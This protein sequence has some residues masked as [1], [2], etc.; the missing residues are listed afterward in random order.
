LN[1]TTLI[2]GNG[3]CAHTIAEDLLTTGADIVMATPDTTC[4]F[5]PSTDSGSAE[6]LTGTRLV[7]CRGT[8]GNFRILAA[9][10]HHKIS[11][12]VADIVIAEEHQRKPN[13]SAYGLKASSNVIPLSRAKQL[14]DSS[15]GPS[16]LS[17]AKKVVFLTGL[18]QESHPVVAEEIMHTA[19]RLQ[20]E[21][22]LQTYILTTNLKVAAN[23][24]EALYRETKEAGTVYIKFTD[25]RPEIHSEGDDTVRIEFIDE[26]TL[27]KF[28]LTPDM[29][30]VDER[31]VPSDYVTELSRILRVDADAG[32]F[33]QADNVHRFTVFTNRKGILVAGPSRSIQAPGDPITEAENVALVW[34]GRNAD[35]KK[36]PEDR[37]EIDKGHCIRCLTC[38]RLC[39]YRAITVNARVVVE[40]GACERCG[41][42]AAQCP[43][44]AIHVKDLEAS[45]SDQ[46]ATGNGLQKDTVTPVLVAFCCSRS[47]VP[48]REL[49]RCTGHNPPAGLKVI[50]VPCSGSVSADHLFSA[51][52]N[53]ADGVLVLACHGGNCHS[54][55]GNMYARQ[56]VDGLT[57]RFAGIGFEKERILMETLASNSGAEFAEI[58]K[59]F[60][61]TILKLG[62]SRLKRN[63]VLI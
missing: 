43:R 59:G 63:E 44:G 50:E 2:F 45:I 57:E 58:V 24:L 9:R 49:A 13:Y 19:L 53:H 14:L 30:V 3:P 26:I 35:H 20:L 39:P 31:I 29:T 60:E 10:N 7:S 16:T 61:E 56:T 18:V 55:R 42:C 62:P 22:N 1:H 17:D 33:L 41:I 37:A 11:R 32:G 6:I 46:L 48:A 54:E 21:F 34:A 25:T 51:F 23:G 5:S 47:A 15:H 38:Y 4:E 8:A 12:T 40:P 28:R 27:K 36:V 52:K